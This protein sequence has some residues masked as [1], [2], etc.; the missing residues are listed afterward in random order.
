[1]AG[2]DAVTSGSLCTFHIPWVETYGLARANQ[3]FHGP[4]KAIGKPEY[5]FDNNGRN[6]GWSI[7]AIHPVSLN[8]G[9][10][11][12]TKANPIL[13]PYKRFDVTT[14]QEREGLFLFYLRT[15]YKA[16]DYLGPGVIFLLRT[17]KMT[18]TQR[19]A[20]RRTRETKKKCERLFW[21]PW[22]CHSWSQTTHGFLS[23]KAQIN[24][25]SSLFLFR[26][27]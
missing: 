14:G 4:K 5:R 24:V 27:N 8:K 6:L 15:S 10:G 18:P 12:G 23:Y 9:T 16:W 17:R 11:L 22:S 26:L 13:L 19:K 21:A 3:A 20:E 25:P 1:M 7:R 2:L